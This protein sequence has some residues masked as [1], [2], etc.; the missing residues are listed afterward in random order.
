MSQSKK[1]SRKNKRS[2]GV[3][4]S[5]GQKTAQKA[6]D[7]VDDKINDPKI[8]EGAKRLQIGLIQKLM[9][10]KM[11]MKH[12]NKNILNILWSVR[13]SKFLEKKKVT[14]LQRDVLFKSAILNELKRIA[15]E[16]NV[17][18]YNKERELQKLEKK[19]L[20]MQ[21]KNTTN[22]LAWQVCRTK[23]I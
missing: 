10:L 5:K 9:M 19:R 22:L 3:C 12:S 7:W 2:E 6:A 20:R 16:Q 17:L 23:S 1:N 14:K 8:K 11:R 15:P 13:S 4:C 21:L 18:I